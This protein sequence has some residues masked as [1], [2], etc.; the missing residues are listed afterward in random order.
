MQ[1]KMYQIFM[2][3]LYKK[4]KLA[5]NFILRTVNNILLTVAKRTKFSQSEYFVK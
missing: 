5:K 1:L 4:L 3:S 2:S